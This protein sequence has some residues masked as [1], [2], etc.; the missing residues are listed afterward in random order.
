GGE[1]VVAA[2]HLFP[3]AA[4]AVLEARFGQILGRDRHLLAGVEVADRAPLDRLRHRLA[5]LLAEPTHEALAIHG[6]LV[7]AVEAAIDDAH[8]AELPAAAAGITMP[9]A[10]ADTIRTAAA[11]A[12]PYS[13]SR[14]CDRRSPG[15]SS[16]R[17]RSPWH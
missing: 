15:A 6:A 8:H 4:A 7:P 16:A 13:P 11:P 14:S 2:E 17:R 10:R 1:L 5:D 12:S 9:C 3:D